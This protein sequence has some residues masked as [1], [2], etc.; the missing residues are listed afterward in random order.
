[1][2]PKR[3]ENSPNL[4]YYIYCHARFVWLASRCLKTYSIKGNM[5]TK[6]LYSGINT[7]C[8]KL[9]TSICS[10]SDSPYHPNA[11]CELTQNNFSIKSFFEPK[12]MDDMKLSITTK[13]EIYTKTIYLLDALIGVIF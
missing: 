5:V 9:G 3:R 11:Q 13:Y 6:L 8:K 1:M 12:K 4:Y 2:P 7:N 10:L